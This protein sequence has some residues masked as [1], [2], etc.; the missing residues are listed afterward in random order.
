MKD[1]HRAS[2]LR[3]IRLVLA[4]GALLPVCMIQGATASAQ[5]P[6]QVTVSV[7]K[8]S[9]TFGEQLPVTITITN[10]SGRPLVIPEVTDF[11]QRVYLHLQVSQPGKVI[12]FLPLPVAVD[13]PNAPA[14]STQVLQPGQKIVF[15]DMLNG[16]EVGPLV[17]TNPQDPNTSLGIATGTFD[18]TAR[19]VIDETNRP[20][21]GDPNVLTGTFISPAIKV[22]IRRFDVCLKDNTTVNMLQFSSTT[23]AYSFTTC[24]GSVA[25]SGIGSVRSVNGILNLTD[26]QRDR[27]LSAG[28]NTGQKTG[29]ATIYLMVGQGVWQTFRINDTTSLGSGC[30]CPGQ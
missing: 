14:E 6:L 11:N 19:L 16:T 27:R 5:G 25:I 26:S 10:V 23:G 9:L 24:N 15:T 8:T 1:F 21:A 29:S 28:F 13:R 3:L 12:F 22:S 18:V 7:V 17:V 20:T 2:R 30:T 4:A